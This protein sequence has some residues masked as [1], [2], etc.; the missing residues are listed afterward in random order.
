VKRSLLRHPAIIAGVVLGLAAVT[1]LNIKT[2]A[3]G[4]WFAADSAERIANHLLPPADLDLVVQAALNEEL[5]PRRRMASAGLG[6]PAITRDPFSGGAASRPA[7]AAATPAKKSAAPEPLVCTAVMLGG[8]EPL[9]L[10]NG[11]THRPGDR[12][13][14][15]EIV[16][17]DTEGVTLVRADGRQRRLA[18][19]PDTDQKPAYRVVTGP[20]T[21]QDRGE[22]HL[23]GELP[24]RNK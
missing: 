24:E 10:I 8:R 5:G 15:E 7:P 9:A 20:S 22:T 4:R 19:G 23:A 2:F 6:G 21:D 17:I 12:L 14:G 18:V 13:R 11:H 16:R 1:V 3:S